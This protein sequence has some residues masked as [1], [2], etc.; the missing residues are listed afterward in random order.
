MSFTPCQPQFAHP[1]K[2]G[3]GSVYSI[4]FCGQIGHVKDKGRLTV[5]AQQMQDIVIAFDSFCLRKRKRKRREEKQK[6]AKERKRSSH[7]THLQKQT[8]PLHEGHWVM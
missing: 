5:H 8:G 3:N 4:G 6:K 1:Y 2:M 7:V